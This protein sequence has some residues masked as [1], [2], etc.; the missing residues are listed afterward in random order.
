[1]R[2]WLRSWGRLG[3]ALIL[4]AGLA[5][6]V[7]VVYAQVPHGEPTPVVVNPS[8]GTH[9]VRDEALAAELSL[10]LARQTWVLVGVGVSM[11]FAS[12]AFFASTQKDIHH[13]RED[14]TEL[15]D[16][17]FGDGHRRI[18]DLEGKVAELKGQLGMLLS[19]RPVGAE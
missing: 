10:R 14:M 12:G 15:K 7:V 17:Y 5:G 9:L 8:T 11:I 1:V 13:L 4:L 16:A 3:G 18:H 2:D 19:L 6:G